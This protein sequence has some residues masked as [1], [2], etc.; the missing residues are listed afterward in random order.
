MSDLLMM[1][2]LRGMQ[3]EIKSM[4]RQLADVQ[5]DVQY[6]KRRITV[7]AENGMD[8]DSSCRKCPFWTNGTCNG[9]DSECHDR[10]QYINKHTAKEMADEIIAMRSEI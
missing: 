10:I 6:L 2:M 8:L 1:N 3:A 7:L 9:H 5:K 4:S